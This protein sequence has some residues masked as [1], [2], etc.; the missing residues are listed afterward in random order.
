[1][2]S[3]PTG[4]GLKDFPHHA[5]AT[6][7]SIRYAHSCQKQSHVQ[8]TATA[9]SSDNSS[10]SS[11]AFGGSIRAHRQEETK[12]LVCAEHKA[13]NLGKVRQGEGCGGV[14][15][16]EGE[17]HSA[18]HEGCVLHEQAHLLLPS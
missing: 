8:P 13:G 17:A 10:S 7:V 4:H 9:G 2:C 14:G 5:A 12:Q 3:M 15:R 11:G 16:H 18:L 6:A 1:M